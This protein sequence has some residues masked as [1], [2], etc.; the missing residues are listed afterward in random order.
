[1]EEQQP[2][3]AAM[4]QSIAIQQNLW[5]LNT[6]FQ[7]ILKQYDD[8]TDVVDFMNKCTTII[9]LNETQ[10]HLDQQLISAILR[11]HL[12]MH[13]ALVD[14]EI[15]PVLLQSTNS[16]GFGKASIKELQWRRFFLQDR[17]MWVHTQNDIVVTNVNDVDKMI[18]N[19]KELK[20]PPLPI[21][22]D[23]TA[24][25]SKQEY[26]VWLH[27]ILLQKNDILCQPVKE[28]HNII[29]IILLL[30]KVTYL[31]QH[32]LSCFDTF[33]AGSGDGCDI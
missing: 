13:N 27:D 22:N 5:Y 33:I 2:T 12:Y 21:Q 4:M 18:S 20:P 24:E 6:L 8:A 28:K 19:I 10:L 9:D 26:V 1:M 29:M 31:K 14:E 11:S 23:I 17:F 30:A 7:H 3:T 15:I 32:L 25:F 16:N